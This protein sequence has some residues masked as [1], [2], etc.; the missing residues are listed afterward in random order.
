MTE[1]HCVAQAGL[2]LLASS[3][4]PT[5]ASRSVGITGMRHCTQSI[6][7][8]L[9]VKW[10]EVQWCSLSS[11]QPQP[12]GLNQSSCFC[13]QII[14]NY[15]HLVLPCY[16]GWSQTPGSSNTPSLVSESAGITGKGCLVQPSFA[17]VA[18][19]GV[20]WCDLGSLQ[21]PPPGSSDS[22][23]SASQIAGITGMCHHTQLILYFCSRDGASPCWSGWSQTPDLSGWAWW[24]TPVIPAL[25]EAKAGRSRGQEF[26]TSLANM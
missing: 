6:P 24:L 18:Q 16:S 9:F 2:E 20:Q 7:I 14:W 3:D 5:L 23:A 11:L 25:W 12:P 15:W 4:P 19:A 10:A 22:P 1:F 13:L 8:L 26:E 17:L 21:P